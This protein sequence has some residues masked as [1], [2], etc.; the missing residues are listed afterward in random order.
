MPSQQTY[1][2][3]GLYTFPNPLSE[4]P[5]GAFSRADNAVIRREGYVETRRGFAPTTATFGSSGHRLQSLSDFAGTLVGHTS[6]NALVRYSGGAFSAYSG[7]Y[8]PPDG[9]R[10]RFLQS[11][12]SLYFTTTTGVKRVDEVTG[13][14]FEAGVPQATGGAVS[15]TGSSGFLPVDSN[16][17]YRYVWGIR[18]ANDRLI[19]GAP[20]GRVAVTNPSGAS[21]PVN[22][23]HVVHV[24]SWVTASYFLQVYRSDVSALA[25]VPASDDMYL[26]YETYP[27]A[28]D[29]SNGTLTFTDVT[30]DELKGAALYSSPNAGVPGSEKFQPP[31]CTDLAEF[32]ERVWCSATTQRQRFLLTLMSVDEDSGGMQSGDSVRIGMEEWTAGGSESGTTFQLYTTGTAA[33]N[34]ASTAQ[35]LVRVINATS[36]TYAA[37]YVSGEYDSPGQILIEAVVLGGMGFYPQARGGGPYWTPAIPWDFAGTDLTRIGDGVTVVV[38][39]AKKHNLQVGQYVEMYTTPDGVNFPGGVKEVASVPSDTSFTYVEAGAVTAAGASDWRTTSPP[40]ASDDSAAP[41][42]LAYA[43][44]G[45]GVDAVP[46]GNYI[47]VGSANYAI[48]RILPL[49]D[50]L[51][52]FKEEGVFTLSGDTPETFSVR[53]FP[54]PARIVAPESAVALGNAIYALTDQ[55]VMVFTENGAQ[56]VSRPIEGTLAEFYAGSEALKNTTAAVAFGV[57]YETEREYHLFLP[58]SDSDTYATQAYVYN[59]VTRAWTRWTLPATCGY[60]LPSDGLEYLGNAAAN[61][62]RVERKTRTASDYQDAT[63]A[64]ISAAIDWQVRTGGDP[65]AYKQWQKATVMLDTTDA[66]TSVLLSVDTEIATAAASG[67]MTTDGLPYVSTYIP[68]EQSRSQTLTVGVSAGV[69]GKRLALRGLTVDYFPSSTSL[70]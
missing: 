26:V 29:I 48:K 18:N 54:T 28:T 7:T 27:S 52:I 14:V 67:T 69:A 51:F 64:A 68:E 30:P 8:T 22:V 61:T 31:V 17:A 3:R 63:G 21:T 37:Y 55:G 20:S 42:S 35:S 57:A 40:V 56:L 19:L 24:P 15:I 36:S 49:G 59:Y 53:A 33:Q 38:D 1:S 65:S 46:L 60:V 58:S 43:E 32:K 41:N 12:K 5:D 10:M 70:R 45:E 66:P 62:V 6:A 34:V 39:L 50:T 9:H 4:V 2:A 47:P 25:S 11:A 13:S 23:T 16:V 44:F